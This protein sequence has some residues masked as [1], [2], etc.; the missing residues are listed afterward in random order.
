[1]FTRLVSGIANSYIV[2]FLKELLSD[3]VVNVDPAQLK[4]SLDMGEV[5]LYNLRLKKDLFDFLSLPL[6]VS[7]GHIGVLSIS[8]PWKALA[9]QPIVITI[10]DALIVLRTKSSEEWDEERERKLKEE[11]K[12]R[13]LEVYDFLCLSAQHE[14][15]NSLLWRI[16]SSLL[17]KLQ[18]KISHAHLR[19]ED[20]QSCGS[21][22]SI[23]LGF[24]VKDASLKSCSTDFSRAPLA[25][26]GGVFSTALSHPHVDCKVA[27][28]KQFGM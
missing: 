9:S 2:S 14:K 28:V 25:T 1:M 12:T 27:D 13:A 23:A 6:I 11:Y 4:S 3:Y 15:S 26:F 5:S 10:S 17:A 21:G 7:I 24:E 18:V 16:A 8:I 22:R 20:S 19:V